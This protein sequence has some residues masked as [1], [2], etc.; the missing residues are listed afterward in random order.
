[1]QDDVGQSQ[2]SRT[3]SPDARRILE[4]PLKYQRREKERQQQTSSSKVPLKMSS[5]SSG[6]MEASSVTK[7]PRRDFKRGHTVGAR[8]SPNPNPN[9]NPNP[10]PQTTTSTDFKAKSPKEK[11]KK[12]NSVSRERPLRETAAIVNPTHTRTPQIKRSISD[13]ELS[14]SRNRNRNRERDKDKE[15]DKDNRERGKDNRYRERDSDGDRDRDRDKDRDG[16]TMDNR[17]KKTDHCDRDNTIGN[18]DPAPGISKEKEDEST[19]GYGMMKYF[20]KFATKQDESMKR[21]GSGKIAKN[22]ENPNNPKHLFHVTIDPTTG[23]IRGLP[24]QWK[25][26][27]DESQLTLAE[28]KDHSSDLVDI[29]RTS[30]KLAEKTLRVQE[31]NLN[32]WDHLVIDGFRPTQIFKFV[33][34]LG[35]GYGGEV[36]LCL[37]TETNE[38][39]ALK[40]TELN[41][42]NE[43]ALANEI[44]MLKTIAHPNIVSYITSYYLTPQY[45]WIVL[46]YMDGGSLSDILDFHKELPLTEQQVMWIMYSVLKG[47]SH[48][49]VMD[50][51]HRDIKSPNIL[52]NH[53]G[54]VKITDFGFAAQLANP[55]EKRSTKLGTPYWMAPE[56][57][58]GKKYGLSADIWSF[59]ILLYEC[60]EG[61][62]PYHDLPK[63]AALLHITKKGCPA[64]SKPE[65]WSPNLIEFLKLC[66]KMR[67]EKRKTAHELLKVRRRR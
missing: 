4:T 63:L 60:V 41:S 22:I 12:R 66:C 50:R 24:A 33:S 37:N 34:K 14:S 42:K 40:K 53:R 56:L 31:N 64:L 8:P 17:D 3:T 23:E 30:T 25:R 9:L 61:G 45:V 54:E 44:Y 5:S 38:L 46:E 7:S 43:V 10:N 28:V 52:L 57:V 65:R 49:H 55:E 6:T 62:P 15:K 29:L 20:S 51:I 1:M 26:M 47:L 58:S 21:S 35:E 27:L 2:R 13:D 67:P 39:V 16:D 19:K 48:L 32:I 18:L 59:G 36:H 11:R